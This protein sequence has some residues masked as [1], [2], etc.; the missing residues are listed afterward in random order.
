MDAEEGLAG[1]EE[2][3][4]SPVMRLR[5]LQFPPLLVED[6]L[7]QLRRLTVVGV[8]TRRDDV[9]LGAVL[10]QLRDRGAI[11]R[12]DEVRDRPLPPARD[13][14]LGGPAS[15]PGVV[16]VPVLFQQEQQRLR[17]L[18]VVPGDR[19]VLDAEPGEGVV[20]LLLRVSLA[21]RL[22]LVGDVEREGL[23]VLCLELV[24]ERRDGGNGK[25]DRPRWIGLR[26]PVGVVLRLSGQYNRGRATVQAV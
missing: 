1:G 13:V 19:L 21:R 18:A 4:G 12:V 26:S 11:D 22:A 25:S 6:G 8:S 5:E 15:R 2:P 10:G 14:L 24:L 20:G 7:G 16:L 23:L 3:A 17:P 9:E